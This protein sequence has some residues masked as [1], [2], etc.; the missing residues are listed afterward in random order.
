MPAITARSSPPPPLPP[1]SI[2]ASSRIVGGGGEGAPGGGGGESMTATLRSFTT[3]PSSSRRVS[4]PPPPTLSSRASLVASTAAVVSTSTA[5]LTSADHSATSVY[6][7]SASSIPASNSAAATPVPVSPICAD[8]STRAC[9][10][11]AFVITTEYSIA[12]IS[13]LN[14][15]RVVS[16]SSWSSVSVMT[17]GSSSPRSVAT[18]L[19][20]AFCIA[21]L[22]SHSAAETPPIDRAPETGKSTDVTS[23]AL[24][25]T[26][27]AAATALATAAV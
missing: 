23:T 15:R 18:P 3:T 8:A 19:R 13:E 22:A 4:K 11:A 10:C 27:R 26:P 9:A 2:S 1:L 17:D 25:S 6:R 7:G 14:R 12:R 16:C 5:K 24:S 20:T 21:E